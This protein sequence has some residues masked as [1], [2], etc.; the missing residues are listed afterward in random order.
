MKFQQSANDMERSLA[1][2]RPGES[3]VDGGQGGGEGQA[4]NARE[5]GTIH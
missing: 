2:L 4:G 1:S 5:H 3:H